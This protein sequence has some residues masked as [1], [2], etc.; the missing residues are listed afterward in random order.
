MVTGVGIATQQASFSVE[1]QFVN[2]AVIKDDAGKDL[3]V[4]VNAAANGLQPGEMKLN[5]KGVK[6]G[7]SAQTTAALGATFKIDSSLRL[8]ID[9]T[10]FSNNYSDWALTSN[11]LVMNSEKTFVTPWRIPTASTI[12][13]NASL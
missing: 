7:G 1:G 12:D 2:T 10:L 6:V 3:T 9:W 13:L 11:D 8:G 5:L 4:L